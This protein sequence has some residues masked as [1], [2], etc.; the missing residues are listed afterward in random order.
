MFC[1]LHRTTLSWRRPLMR[2]WY[3]AQRRL[4]CRLHQCPAVHSTW[5]IHGRDHVT[6]R[7][8][9]AGS[10]LLRCANCFK[11]LRPSSNSQSRHQLWIW[12][13][14]LDSLRSVQQQFFR[15]VVFKKQIC[16]HI[17]VYLLFYYR[18][19]ECDLSF[20]YWLNQIVH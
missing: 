1:R 3:R 2:H 15:S 8:H 16:F 10:S 9:D 14:V 17:F 13:P 6:L 20:W 18:P 7:H 12:Q 5:F 4:L 19:P 11:F